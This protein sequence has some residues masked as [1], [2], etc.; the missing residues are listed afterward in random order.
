MAVARVGHREERFEAQV[1]VEVP[2]LEE[3]PLE[4]PLEEVQQ[5]ELVA[6]VLV[7]EALEQV[8]QQQEGRG[9]QP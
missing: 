3:E 2:P 8:D 4:E 9:E 5:E 1:V 7:E 6:Q